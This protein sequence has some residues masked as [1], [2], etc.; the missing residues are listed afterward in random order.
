MIQS[1]LLATRPSWSGACNLT[2]TAPD[3]P[4]P[5]IRPIAGTLRWHRRYNSIRNDE[6]SRYNNPRTWMINHLALA[7][8]LC[9]LL[10]WGL[11][12]LHLDVSFRP[13]GEISI[14][15]HGNA[16]DTRR[17]QGHNLR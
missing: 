15:F 12:T 9:K 8:T 4:P 16:T 5:P 17:I 7:S 10:Y 14:A 2:L 3:I 6:R 13:K 11:I 1:L